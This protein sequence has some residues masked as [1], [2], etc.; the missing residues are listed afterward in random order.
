MNINL[1][2]F[3]QTIAFI[4]FVWF[5]LKYIW[6]PLINAL[7]E[8]KKTIADG[9]AAAV[10][11]QQAQERG[12]QRAV[13]IIRD[14]KTQAQEI[15]AS[16]EKRRNEIVEEAKIEA[17]DEGERLVGAAHAEIEQETHRAREELRGQLAS[18]VVAGASQ[19]LDK[20]VDAATHGQM[21]DGLV[22]QL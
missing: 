7:N 6:P 14:A 12:E 21:L 22:G 4:V 1:T 9:L 10:H 3:G 5:C 11:G 2:L 16:A 13:E 19:I 8:R 18:L 17:K 15:L 20:E